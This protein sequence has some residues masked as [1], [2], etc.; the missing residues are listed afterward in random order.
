MSYQQLLTER[1]ERFARVWQR[2]LWAHPELDPTV[3]EPTAA[4]GL[5][6]TQAQRA[7]EQERILRELSE[8]A[9]ILYFYKGDCPLC[10]AQSPLL[11]SFAEAH[12]FRIVPISLDGFTDPVFPDTKMDRG[13]AEKLGVKNLPAIFLARPPHDVRRVGTGFLTIEELGRRLIRMART[14]REDS[15][16]SGMTEPEENAYENHQG[17]RL[18]ESDDRTALGF[19]GAGWAPTAA[20]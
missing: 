4:A 8:T 15:G 3:V 18:S 10:S 6:A 19:G 13:A 5:A 14:T 20:R 17:D 2:V 1:A 12:G 11:S 9:G 16:V 7:F